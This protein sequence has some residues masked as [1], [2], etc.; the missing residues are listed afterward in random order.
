[1]AERQEEDCGEM[2]LR[3]LE[4]SAEERRAIIC[5]LESDTAEDSLHVYTV[6]RAWYE[7]WKTYVGLDQPGPAQRLS[8]AASDEPTRP[9]TE[10]EDMAINRSPSTKTTDDSATITSTTESVTR[11]TTSDTRRH[12][13]EPETKTNLSARPGPIEMDRADGD[14]ISVDEKVYI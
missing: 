14:N 1:M 7:R 2:E 6:S 9:T 4:P 13:K 10:W 12:G 5:S 11:S 8:D 3:L